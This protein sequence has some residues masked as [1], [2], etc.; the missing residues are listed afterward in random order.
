M[1]VKCTLLV[2]SHTGKHNFQ[3]LW[4]SV[5]FCALKHRLYVFLFKNLSSTL[6]S[7]W[8]VAFK[9][10]SIRICATRYTRV[11]LFM[12]ID[13]LILNKM[14]SLRH[15]CL[16]I[17]I[18]YIHLSTWK[19]FMQKEESLVFEPFLPQQVPSF[20]SVSSATSYSYSHAILY[21]TP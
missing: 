17:Q 14:V 20:Y 3:K 9:S 10:H 11:W 1:E 8:F 7:N 21:F 16:L 13:S 2:F 5:S 12:I 15:K 19:K 6:N 18:H 4:I